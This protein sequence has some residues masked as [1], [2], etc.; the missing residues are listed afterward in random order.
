MNIK[1]L[2]GSAEWDSYIFRDISERRRVSRGVPLI[3]GVP[4]PL[5]PLVIAMVDVSGGILLCRV[6][7]RLFITFAERAKGVELA[8]HLRG[9]RE[10]N[11]EVEEFLQG[12]EPSA[13]E[14][15]GIFE[16]YPRPRRG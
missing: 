3:I 13:T 2:H 7:V 14:L 1:L 11:L 16:L 15:L 4:L 10:R 8:S 5:Q 12:Y 9:D 6:F